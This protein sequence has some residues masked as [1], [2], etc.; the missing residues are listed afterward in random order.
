ALHGGLFRR[1][2]FANLAQSLEN[3]SECLPRGC[4]VRKGVDPLK[5]EPSQE[6]PVA[7]DRS[8]PGR[9]NG[10]CPPSECV[11]AQ[12]GNKRQRVA[13]QGRKG[14]ETEC[15]ATSD[16]VAPTNLRRRLGEEKFL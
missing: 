16:S 10:T 4:R 5:R 7:L 9:W 2:G 1:T 3:Q 12:I 13:G 15:I 14:S 8:E 6:T 11:I